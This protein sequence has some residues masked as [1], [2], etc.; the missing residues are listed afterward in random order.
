[1]IKDTALA[2]LMFF[3]TLVEII[4]FFAIA[5]IIIITVLVAACIEIIYKIL[6]FLMRGFKYE[7]IN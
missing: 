6:K 5:I 1:M 2:L 7:N 4:A 3:A